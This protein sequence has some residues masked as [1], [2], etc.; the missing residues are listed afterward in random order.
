M[1]DLDPVLRCD[2]CRV[3]VRVTSLH[4]LGCCDKC[5]NKR[6]RNVTLFNDAERATMEAWGETEFLAQFSEVANA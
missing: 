4:K 2:S 6:M 5:G 1:S 3:L